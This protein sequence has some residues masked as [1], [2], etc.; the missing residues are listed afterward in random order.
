[1]LYDLSSS[2]FEGRSCP[3][4]ALG[5]SRDAKRGRL[6]VNYGLICSPEGRPVAVEVFPGNTPDQ[7][8]FPLAVEA[9]TTRFLVSRVI[10]VGDRGMITRAQTETLKQQGAGFITALRSAQ[11]RSLL[12]SGAL[13]LS[14]FD[15]V[16]LAEITAPEFPGERLIV[17]RNPRVAAERARKREALLTATEAELAQVKAMVEGPRGRLRAAPAGVIGERVGRVADRYQVAKHFTLAIA[18]GAFSFRRKEAQIREEAALD[19]FYVLR[20]TCPKEEL[21]APAVVRA[22][23][24]LKE[25]EDAF[26]TMKSPELEIRP[27]YHHLE[28]R[29]RAHIFLCMLAYYVAFTSAAHCVNRMR[30]SLNG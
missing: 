4:A 5:Y 14:L 13:Q 6:Q 20:T 29:V 9:V 3:L 17:C 30:A 22:Y 19:G 24:Q 8:T 26:H 11:V 18:D 12:S 21:G 7:E 2:Y 25:V 23:K 1:M 16:N 10:F 27:I 28:D 15:E